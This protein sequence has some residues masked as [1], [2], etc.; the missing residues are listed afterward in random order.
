MIVPIALP[1][2]YEEALSNEGWISEAK[3]V[4][5]DGSTAIASVYYKAKFNSFS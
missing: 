5:R 4:A 1:S 3:I 2:C